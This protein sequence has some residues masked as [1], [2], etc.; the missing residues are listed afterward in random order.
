VIPLCSLHVL[1]QF[2]VLLLD[3]FKAG[4]WRFHS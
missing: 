1:E 2:R 3:D 4:H